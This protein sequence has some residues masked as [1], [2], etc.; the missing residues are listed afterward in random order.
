MDPA[1]AKIIQLYPNPNQAVI[2]G[3]APTNDYYYNTAGAL[4]PIKAMRA[5]T[6][7]SATRTACLDR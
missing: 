6:I 2:T 7:A 3:N 1:W 4:T 5:S